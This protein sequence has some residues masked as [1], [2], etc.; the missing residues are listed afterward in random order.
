MRDVL[1]LFA[2]FAVEAWAEQQ[3]SATLSL[4]GLSQQYCSGDEDVGQ[5]RIAA[6]L[7]YAN[8]SKVP[9]LLFRQSHNVESIRLRLIDN[10]AGDKKGEY[11]ISNSTILG[12]LNV[13]PHYSEQ[14]FVRLTPGG[15]YSEQIVFSF[16]FQRLG[17]KYAGDLPTDGG[18]WLSINVSIWPGTLGEA[19][20]LKAKFSNAT[21]LTQP[22]WSKPVRI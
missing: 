20:D 10:P 9:V 5:I 8:M 18:Y 2:L 1:F 16:P 14:D 21:I 13:T 12:D 19:T 17:R 7:R 4:E 11:N 3:Q 6:R 15:I 22:V